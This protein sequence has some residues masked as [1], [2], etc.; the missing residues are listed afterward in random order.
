MAFSKVQNPFKKEKKIMPNYHQA[1]GEWDERIGSARVQAKNWRLLALGNVFATVCLI[2]GIIYQSQQSTVE[3]FV[4]PV[5][6]IGKPGEIKLMA[7]RYQPQK[8]EVSY[9]LADWIKNVRSKSV[10][11]IVIRENWLKA[12]DFLSPVAAQTLNEYAENNDPFEN[13]GQEA[14]NVEVSS[15]VERTDNT[16]QI[17]WR[18]L[19]YANGVLI[20]QDSYTGL[21]TIEVNPPQD[22]ETMFTNPLG[23][24][25]KNLSWEREL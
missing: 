9:F 8:A 15:V 25:I 14:K 22:R 10:D 16:Y 17:Q 24:Y 6:E 19:L 13:V 5:N 18:E 11:P 1:A 4:V 7:D 3:A 20:Q 21:F 12:Y 2:G 23:I